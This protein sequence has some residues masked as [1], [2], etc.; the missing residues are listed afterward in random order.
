MQ[1]QQLIINTSR[2]YTNNKSKKIHRTPTLRAEPV[3]P[4]SNINGRNH[5]IENG[6]QNNKGNEDNS[7][8]IP[9]EEVAMVKQ[10]I[11]HLRTLLGTLRLA[12]TDIIRDKPTTNHLYD[13]KTAS[14]TYDTSLKPTASIND[15]RNASTQTNN[16]EENT[17]SHTK[18]Q[19][20][21]PLKYGM[22]RHNSSKGNAVNGSR[23]VVVTNDIIFTPKPPL[24]TKSYGKRVIVKTPK[25][26]EPGKEEAAFNGMVSN[27]YF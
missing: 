8:L 3:I 12:L 15:D 1:A 9:A 14:F 16:I 11:T 10:E 19:H 13:T 22:I 6:S 21:R 27:L 24:F 26:P 5:H 23:T 7:V 2:Q 25:S 18:N 17:N 20:I 4:I